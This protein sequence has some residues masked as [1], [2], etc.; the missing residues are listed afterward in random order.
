MLA[1]VA[2]HQHQPVP[3]IERQALDDREPSRAEVTAERDAETARPEPA[4]RPGGE[5]DQ[6]ENQDERESELDG[7]N[8]GHGLNGC[9]GLYDAD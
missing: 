7:G 5:G 3:R 9:E 1:V 6:P 4:Q 8:G 2:A